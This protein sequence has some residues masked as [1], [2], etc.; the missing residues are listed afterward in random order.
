MVPEITGYIFQYW[1]MVE[2]DLQVTD[3]SGKFVIDITNYSEIN[4]E[5]K[6]KAIIYTITYKL[7]GGKFK[8]SVSR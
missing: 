7:E 8:D 4:L 2:S 1:R 3:A 6:T 5:P